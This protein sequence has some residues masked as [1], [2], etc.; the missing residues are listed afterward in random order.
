MIGSFAAHSR[1]KNES[2]KTETDRVFEAISLYKEQEKKYELA[3]KN[4]P[5]SIKGENRDIQEGLL[6]A[7]LKFKSITQKDMPVHLTRDLYHGVK[8][9]A[10]ASISQDRKDEIKCTIEHVMDQ[11]AAGIHS[12]HDLTHDRIEFKAK[13]NQI[14]IQDSIQQYYN[15]LAH[16][17]QQRTLDRELHKNLELSL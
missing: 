8:K 5:E 16:I 3:L 9:I 11:K 17:E 7:V 15:K 1:L 4:P 12:L 10:E 13:Q 2:Y 14:K 6:H